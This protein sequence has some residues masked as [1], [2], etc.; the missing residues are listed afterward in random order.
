VQRTL[1]LL[2]AVCVLL[3]CRSAS[4]ETVYEFVEVCKE[5]KLGDCFFRIQE[6][7]TRLNAEGHRR[8]C[9]PRTFGSTMVLDASVPV[10]VLDHVRLGLS[11]ARFGSAEDDVDQVISKIVGTIYP[12]N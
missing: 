7:L 2:T 10:S 3:P 1:A 6:R 9:L 12:C 5:E 11:A 8:V 4:A